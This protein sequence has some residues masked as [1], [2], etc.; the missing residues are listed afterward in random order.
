MAF[1]TPAQRGAYDRAGESEEAP[2]E[3]KTRR[4]K[5]VMIQHNMALRSKEN[6]THTV[7]RLITHSQHTHTHT[8]TI[9]TH[10]CTRSSQSRTDCARSVCSQ[11]R[12][13]NPII[14]GHPIRQHPSPSVVL[15]AL[16]P[17]KL[18]L[19]DE[20]RAIFIY[21]TRLFSIEYSPFSAESHRFS[22]LSPTP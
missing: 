4:R 12:R 3:R 15:R 5:Q 6:N 1:Y 21:K 2:R 9:H 20:R 19:C 8:H 13:D 14:S 11:R 17:R 7:G 22:D 10:S 16:A 18:P